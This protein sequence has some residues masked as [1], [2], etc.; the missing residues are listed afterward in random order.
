M[1]LLLYIM[2]TFVLYLVF[3][4][5]TDDPA[6][7]IVLMASGFWLLLLLHALV[8]GGVRIQLLRVGGRWRR[9]ARRIEL[10]GLWFWPVAVRI[11]ALILA[12]LAAFGCFSALTDDYFTFDAE[13]PVPAL[14]VAATLLL[15]AV[16]TWRR[17]P[18]PCAGPGIVLDA[19]GFAITPGS[20]LGQAF[21]WEDGPRVVGALRSGPV[22][23][24]VPGIGP[25]PVPVDVGTMPL[26][27]VQLGRVLEFYS[28]HP[29]L[30]HELATDRGLEHV[31]ALAG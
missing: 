29:E 13:T 4:R 5:Y 3:A 2:L 14:A 25:E 21:P 6:T 30:R 20:R 24:R 28:D 22:L 12:L 18:R 26:T 1:R 19:E 9:R 16:I 31:R 17:T 15:V 23:L 27:Y 11:G 7:S 8:V 10:P